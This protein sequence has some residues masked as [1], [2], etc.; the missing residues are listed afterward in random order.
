MCVYRSTVFPLRPKVLV[1]VCD[2]FSL[3]PTLDVDEALQPLCDT[4][5][6]FLWNCA[7]SA[8]RVTNH[9]VLSFATVMI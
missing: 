6:T 5:L 2:L 8:V 7:S 3:I 1:A 4:A 9:S